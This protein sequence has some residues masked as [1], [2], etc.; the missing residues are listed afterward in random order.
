MSNYYPYEQPHTAY[1]QFCGKWLFK[2]KADSRIRTD[3]LSLKAIALPLSYAGICADTSLHTLCTRP[4]NAYS[5]TSA[6]HHRNGRIRTHDR[7]QTSE[8]SSLRA[9]L[10]HRLSRS[11]LRKGYGLSFTSSIVGRCSISTAG[12]SRSALNRIVLAVILK[13]DVKVYER[14]LH[15]KILLFP[16]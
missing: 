8:C 10:R 16:Q 12:R 1:L 5:I 14:L 4:H 9:S 15:G 7:S 3:N 6:R 11:F 13:G 2:D